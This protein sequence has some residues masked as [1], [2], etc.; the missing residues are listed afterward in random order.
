MTGGKNEKKLQ[1]LIAATV[2]VW[3]ATA[4]CKNEASVGDFPSKSESWRCENAHSVRDFL[5]N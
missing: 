1:K 4:T 3:T 5:Q 2:K